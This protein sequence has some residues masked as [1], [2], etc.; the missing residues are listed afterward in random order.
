MSLV[1]HIRNFINAHYK[2]TDF[3]KKYDKE[4]A[5]RFVNNPTAGFV[6]DLRNYTQHY[7]LPITGTHFEIEVDPKTQEI[8]SFTNPI[9]LDKA[10]LLEWENWT[11]EHG[12]P[13]LDAADDRI[14][15]QVVVVE[16]A[17]AVRDFKQWIM[18]NLQKFHA[19]ELK[20]LKET[21][22]EIRKARGNPPRPSQ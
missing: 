22:R 1:A 13:Y 7:R 16:Y 14:D 5:K 2:G 17:R 19:D 8:S 20:W 6:Q 4:K 12:K 21:E 9:T 3:Y 15:V 18:N 11:Q 10:R